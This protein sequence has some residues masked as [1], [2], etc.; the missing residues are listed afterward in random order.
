MNLSDIAVLV[1]AVRANSLAGAGRRLGIAPM[2]ASRRL[3]S[4]EDELGVR[5]LQR[6][7]RALS[8]T[9]EGEAF[10]PHAQAMLEARAEAIGAIRPSDA[11]ASG[12]L[13]VTASV[14][15]GRQVVAPFI[16]AFLRANPDAQ[17]DLLLTDSVVDIVGGGIDLAIRIARLRDSG[18]IARKLA[19]N[20]LGLYA[21]PEYLQQRGTPRRIAELATQECLAI[22][23]VRHWSFVLPGGRKVRQRI[24]GRFTASSPEALRE[25]GVGGAGI[26][27]L[28][29]WM[30]ADDV[31]A[32][33]LLPITLE[34]GAPE[35]L[36][37]WAV[38]ASAR[39]VPAKTRLFMD[40]LAAHLDPTGDASG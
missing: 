18:L 12:L 33:R 7:T 37:I 24:G 29:G 30:A 14:P 1:E 27:Q 19:P 38:H 23:G 32:G 34:D 9:P 2:L 3:A 4:L 16:A 35:P 25:V 36:D 40:G 6:T 28:S 21:S 15:F 26:V 8:L 17:V 20:P 5:L 10:L 39:L 31:T 13:R 22:S 11:G